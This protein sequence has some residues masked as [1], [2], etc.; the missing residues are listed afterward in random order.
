M[1]YLDTSP[2]YGRG[3]SEEVLGRALQG[4]P[5]EKFFVSS[6]VGRYDVDKFDFSAERVVKSID[7]SLKRLQLDH[8]DLVICHDIEFGDLDMIINETIPALQ[9]LRDQEKKLRFIGISGLPL[10]IFK[11]VLDRT[12]AVDVILTYCHHTLL[13]SSADSM[14]DYLTEKKVGI[15]NASP[16]GMGLLTRQGPPSWHPAPEAMKNGSPRFALP[17]ALLWRLSVVA[18]NCVKLFVFL[19]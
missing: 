4:I 18:H 16:T 11:Y 12:D 8:I 9:R 13:D 6:K 14:L 5:R 15:I 1:N 2:F 3:R 10:H 19:L 7:E 17:F